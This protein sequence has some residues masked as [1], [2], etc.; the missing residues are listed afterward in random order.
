MPGSRF[1]PEQRARAVR[2]V[3]EARPGHESEWAAIGGHVPWGGV[4]SGEAS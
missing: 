1:S 3:A 2:L 4:S